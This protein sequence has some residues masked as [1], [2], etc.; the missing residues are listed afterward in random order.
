MDIQTP[1]IGFMT[2]MELLGYTTNLKWELN[3]SWGL[4][5]CKKCQEA[6]WICIC[7]CIYIYIDI[8]CIDK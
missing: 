2:T 1:T 7:L 6:V 5:E 3:I 4:E 8:I